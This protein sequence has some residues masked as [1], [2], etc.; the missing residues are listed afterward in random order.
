MCLNP[1]QIILAHCFEEGENVENAK[2]MDDVAGGDANLYGIR[3]NHIFILLDYPS[4]MN[5]IP[6][7]FPCPETKILVQNKVISLV[8]KLINFSIC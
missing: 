7:L 5:N 8:T 2:V 1:A 3:E 6:P 4:A